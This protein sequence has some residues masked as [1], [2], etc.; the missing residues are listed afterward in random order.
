MSPKDVLRRLPIG[1]HETE[2]TT[3]YLDISNQSLIE[4]TESQ[5]EQCASCLCCRST[6]LTLCLDQD[7]KVCKLVIG[8]RDGVNL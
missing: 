6:F 3:E 2:I 8:I 4:E 1:F 5:I 7:R